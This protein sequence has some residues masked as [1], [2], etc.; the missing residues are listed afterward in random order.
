MT[1][2]YSL[3]FPQVVHES[4]CSCFV[5]SVASG[6]SGAS[7]AAELAHPASQV[8]MSHAAATGSTATQANTN[9]TRADSPR[10]ILSASGSS[11]GVVVIVDPG[12]LLSHSFSTPP[13]STHCGVLP[14]SRC[15]FSQR[16]LARRRWADHRCL[17][18]PFLALLRRPRHHCIDA[19]VTWL[20]RNTRLTHAANCP[21]PRRPPQPTPPNHRPLRLS[22][23]RDPRPRV[24]RNSSS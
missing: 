3:S 16:Q 17:W 2:H 24:V 13:C 14:A 12:R 4:S 20:T 1:S 23:R 9:P 8:C 6:A 18:F 22:R 19:Q 15:A 10:S 7:V 11:A 5:A 21:S